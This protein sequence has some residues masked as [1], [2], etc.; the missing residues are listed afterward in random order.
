VTSQWLAN[1]QESDEYDTY[2]VWVLPPF[3]D[4]HIMVDDIG[5]EKFNAGTTA[6]P[7]W[8]ICTEAGNLIGTYDDKEI[9]ENDWKGALEF[10]Y[11]AED[12]EERFSTSLAERHAYDG[13]DEIWNLWSIFT[14]PDRYTELYLPDQETTSDDYAAPELGGEYADGNEYL[15]TTSFIAPNSEGPE[16]ELLS[17]STFDVHDIIDRASEIANGIETQECKGDFDDDGDIDLIDFSSFAAAYN[18]V[19]ADANYSTAGDFDD[20]GDIDLIDFSSFAAVYNT[21]CP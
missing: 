14:R 1:I 20:D 21:N 8:E 7:D 12:T 18:S 15:I 19:S 4:P 9:P 16:R 17:K 13:S 11:I 2:I 6:N 10:Y 3:N 5:L